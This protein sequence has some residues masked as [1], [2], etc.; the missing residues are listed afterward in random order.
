MNQFEDPWSH[1]VSSEN[2]TKW[3]LLAA[4]FKPVKWKMFNK[5]KKIG[6]HKNKDSS[7]YFAHH[8]RNGLSWAADGAYISIL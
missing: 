5:E 6:C 7:K 1:I 4:K 8:C 3:Y 2:A